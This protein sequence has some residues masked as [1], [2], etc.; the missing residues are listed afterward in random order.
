MMEIITAL[1]LM[2]SAMA[3]GLFM[4]PYGPSR[5]GAPVADEFSVPIITACAM[6]CAWRGSSELLALAGLSQEWCYYSPCLFLLGCGWGFWRSVSELLN[7]RPTR[8]L[9]LPQE[10]ASARQA[11]E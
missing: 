9:D 6:I 3:L 8:P 10:S 2:A 11:G 4:I 1:G 7:E 5:P